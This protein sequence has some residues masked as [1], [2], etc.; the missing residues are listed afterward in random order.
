MIRNI[1]FDI[2]NVLAAFRWKDYIRENLGYDGETAQRLGRATT[3]HPMW[4]EYDRGGICLNDI[5]ETMIKSD[6]EIEPQ[7]RHFFA[8]RRELVREYDYSEGWIRE[9]KSRGYKIFILSNYSE[10]H[11]RFIYRNFKFFGQEDGKVISYEEKLLKPDR[12]IYEVLLDRYGLVPSETVF[13]DDTPANIDGAVAVGMRGIVF[14]NYEQGRNEL[15]KLL[16]ES[17]S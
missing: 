12:A 16:A 17:K 15:E 4:R 8:D 14:E 10:D 2:G 13:L 1:V 5:I 11:F 6:P 7:I 3:Q 9:L